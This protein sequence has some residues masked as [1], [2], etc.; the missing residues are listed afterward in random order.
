MAN[1]TE[2]RDTL[3][4]EGPFASVYL[5]ASHDTEDAAKLTELRWRAAQDGLAALEA[6]EAVLDVLAE[7]IDRP[8]AVGRA[9]RLLVATADGVLVDEYLAEPPAQL[10][11]RVSS[12]P[13]LLPLADWRGNE[14]PHVAVAID[15]T[16]ADLLAVDA[17]G[18]MLTEEVAGRDHP[19]H[20]VRAGGW[21]HLNIQ[22]RAEETVRRN[23]T[24]VAAEVASLASR[25]GARLV[26]V[27]GDPRARSQLREALPENVRHLVAEIGHGRAEDPSHHTVDSA[28]TELLADRRRAELDEMLDRLH[29]ASG[30]PG[31][32]V[33]GLPD[34]TGAL[35]D[36]N[37][38][39]L[40]IDAQTLDDRTVWTAT[41]H[42]MVATSRQALHDVGVSD[43]GEIRADEALPVAAVMSGAEVIASFGGE[44]EFKFAGGVGALLRHR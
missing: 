32:A 4:H 1:L 8:P 19:V 34:T 12:M 15:Q 18:S 25:T 7:A 26:A 3:S 39:V 11:V 24:D 36:G 5:D 41:E 38:S 35:R 2:L 29:S 28:I 21:A 14:V 27:A 30:S 20:K 13:Y 33:E 10:A 37:V 22:R 43:R 44:P 31:L 9:G 40:L 23:V 42:T 17:N 16:G 6:S